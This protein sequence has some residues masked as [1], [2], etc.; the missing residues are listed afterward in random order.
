MDAAVALESMPRF[1]G[2]GGEK[3]AAALERF[4]IDLKGAHILDVGAS[5]GGFTDCALQAGAADA[6]CVDVGRSQLHG[7]LLADPRVKNFEQINARHLK[8]SDLPRSSFDAIV[9]DLSF[10][11]APLGPSRCLAAFGT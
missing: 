1:V 5:T 7:K 4:G 8:A 6:V 2:G 11:I 10:Y 9:M 3:L